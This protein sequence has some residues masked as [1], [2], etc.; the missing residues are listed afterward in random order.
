MHKLAIIGSRGV[1][2]SLLAEEFKPCATFNSDTINQLSNDSYDTILC[3]APS[4]NRRLALQDPTSDMAQIQSIIQALEQTKFNRIILISSIDTVLYANSPY[5]F[6]RLQL[7]NYVLS[8]NQ[9]HVIRL[10]T[11]IGPTIKKNVLYDL[12]NWQFVENIN[13]Q[14]QLQWYDLS[15]LASD[16]QNVINQDIKSITLVSEPIFNYDIIAKFFPESQNN[17]GTNPGPELK[18]NIQPYQTTQ[19]EIFLA[20]EKYLR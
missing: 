10:C 7:E 9:A 11:L 8:F 20:M 18:Y 6:N 13:Q 5:G 14:S 2:G 16:I 3:S 17:I 4:G 12:K 1:I 15:N 19:A